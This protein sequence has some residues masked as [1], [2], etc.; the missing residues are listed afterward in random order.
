M[1]KEI[2]RIATTT[3]WFY[4]INS[5]LFIKKEICNTT[6]LTIYKTVYL[7]TLLY[8]YNT[9]VLKEELH[10]KIQVQKIKYL[11]KVAKVTIID[12]IKNEGIRKR[13]KIESVGIYIEKT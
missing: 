8:G 10:K 4:A 9:W 5:G 3:K 6:K 1:K 7:P 12:K 2:N 11:R 13:L